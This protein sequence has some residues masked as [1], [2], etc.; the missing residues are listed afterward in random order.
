MPNLFVPWK[1][2]FEEIAKQ[3]DHEEWLH[4]ALF[5]DR[6]A[7][8]SPA[9][10]KQIRSVAPKFRVRRDLEAFSDLRVAKQQ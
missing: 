7:L 9:P 5:N 3:P 10:R 8:V 2:F 4:S 6:G 1:A